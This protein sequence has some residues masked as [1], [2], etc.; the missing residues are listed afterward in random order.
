[1]YIHT[2]AIIEVMP[3]D[4]ISPTPRSSSNHHHLKLVAS[5]PAHPTKLTNKRSCLYYTWI[6]F[7]NKTCVV[8]FEEPRA[9]PAVSGLAGW[10]AEEEEETVTMPGSIYISYHNN[11]CMCSIIVLYHDNILYIYVCMPCMMK[12]YTHTR[13]KK[14][15]DELF[16]PP[17]PALFPVSIYFFS[18]FSPGP[19]T[20]GR[21]VSECRQGNF[22]FV[23]STHK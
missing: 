6:I 22:V 9:L 7:T 5:G 23:R 14:K 13:W 20:P 17:W 11:I 10:H 15:A 3:W 21:S 18:W 16:L 8:C 1:M 19:T 4:Q 12:T 2:Y